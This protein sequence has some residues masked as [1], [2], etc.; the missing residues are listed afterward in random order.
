MYGNKRDLPKTK[1][2]LKKLLKMKCLQTNH[3]QFKL[4]TKPQKVGCTIKTI[5]ED[6]AAVKLT[7]SDNVGHLLRLTN[8]RNCMVKDMLG[9]NTFTRI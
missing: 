7:H 3:F 4:N 8:G 2:N 6:T 1:K 9:V 5:G